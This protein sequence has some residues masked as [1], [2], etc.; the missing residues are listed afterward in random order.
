MKKTGIIL[1]VYNQKENLKL[2]YESLIR[3]SYTYFTVYFVDNNSTDG[4]YEHSLELN[5]TYN[6]DIKYIFPGDNTGFAKGN[7]IGAEKAAEDKC[8]Y[9]FILN[10]DTE[11]HEDCLK[12]LVQLAGQDEMTAVTSPIIFY[13]NKKNS[14]NII[15]EYGSNINFINCKVKK[16][17][18]QD[19]FEKSN[20]VIPG[21]KEV[22][23]VSGG[24]MLIK[25]SVYKKTGLWEERYFAYGDEADLMKRL[26][27]AGYKIKVTK[28]AMLWHNHKWTPENKKGYYFEY[29]LIERNKFLFFYRNKL[30]FSLIYTLF[31]DLIKF[32]WRLLWFKKVCDFKLGFYYLK[33]LFHGLLNIKGKPKL[34]FVK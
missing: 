6:L 29:Y 7:N 16:F 34:K 27:D 15:Q 19:N 2:L 9:I 26:N 21:I 25:T 10:N 8:E 28:M 22:N 11:L 5:K 18:A 1:V 4:S 13:G 17:F 20:N 24:A 31:M 23:F 33:G 32:P 14:D 30:Y 3:Q 12:Y